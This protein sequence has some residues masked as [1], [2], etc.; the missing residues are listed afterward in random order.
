[1]RLLYPRVNNMSIPVGYLPS[2]KYGGLFL[3][4]DK[5]EKRRICLAQLVESTGR[6]GQKKVANKILVEPSYI[7]RALYP[8]GKK[9]KKNI[10]DDVVERLDK[11]F[12][13]WQALSSK[14]KKIAHAISILNEFSEDEIDE[15]I[16]GAIDRAELVR[17]VK[18]NGTK[19]PG[20]ATN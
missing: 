15:A 17:R 1:M 6:G 8:E 13:G 12:P 9:G 2:G 7:S 4:M 20:A 3:S 18:K 10:G 5:Y 16:K 11:E 14:D 19:E